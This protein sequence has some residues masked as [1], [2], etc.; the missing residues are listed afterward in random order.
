MRTST[1]SGLY[2]SVRDTLEG[3]GAYEYRWPLMAVAHGEDVFC[4]SKLTSGAIHPSRSRFLSSVGKSRCLEICGHSSLQHHPCRRC[5]FP[6]GPSSS[7]F[8]LYSIPSLDAESSQPS[9]HLLTQQ[10][11]L[12]WCICL[13]SISSPGLGVKHCSS[14]SGM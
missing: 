3:P 11:S 14:H 8:K 9:I 1:T 13:A 12:A 10:P 4:A 6:I 2:K 7:Q 5:D